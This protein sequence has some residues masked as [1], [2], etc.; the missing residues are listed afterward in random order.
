MKYSS[1]LLAAAVLLI[2]LLPA[3]KTLSPDEALARLADTGASRLSAPAR[4]A[5]AQPRLT[6]TATAADGEV[7]VYVFQSPAADGYMV[8]SADDC[9]MPL[10]GYADCGTIAAADM[11]PALEWWLGEYARQ[12]EYMRA[13][14][15]KASAPMRVQRAPIAPQIKTSWDQGEPYNA[16]CPTYGTD[17]TWTGCVATAMAQVMNYWKYPERGQGQI[18]YSCTSLE[19]R[20]SLNFALRA[21]DWDNMLDEYAGG[22]WTDAQVDAVAYL[23]KACGYA[24]KMDYGLDSSG[25]LAM[26]IPRAL[27]K[28]FNYDGNIEYVLRD[29]CSLTEWETKIYN[30]LKDVGPILYGGGSMIGGGHS[31]ICD[32]YD[33]NGYFHFNW[34]WTG[35][36][37]GYYTLD[38]LNPTS[39]GAGGG[40]GGGYNFTQDCV[41]GIQPPTG[42]PVVEQPVT[43]VQC[44]SITGS[45][46]DG[47]LYIELVGNSDPAWVNYN[48]ETLEVVFGAFVQ[49]VGSTERKVYPIFDRAIKVMPGYGAYPSTIHPYLDLDALNLPDGSYTISAAVAEQADEL[50]WRD[51]KVMWGDAPTM[52]LTRKGSDYTIDATA[53]AH[54][55]IVSARLQTPVIYGMLARVTLTATNPNDIE[56]SRG[57]A[58]VLTIN[59]ELALLG[60]SIMVSLNPGETK[61]F[62][63]ITPLYAMS[64]YFTVDKPMPCQLAF[65]DEVTY[66]LMSVAGMPTVLQPNPGVPAIVCDTP[67]VVVNATPKQEVVQDVNTIVFELDGRE[68]IEVKA[69]LLLRRGKF[70]YQVYACIAS[71]DQD[72]PEL[73][74]LETYSGYPM[75]F[76]AE[77]EKQEFNAT[78]SF[79]QGVIGQ[80]YY[81]MMGYE[82]GSQL[83]Q[84]GP[85]VSVF[86]Y[87]AS[88]VEDVCAE[89][90][91]LSYDGYNVGAP[92]H[93]I[94]IYSL[95][96]TAMTAGTDIVS[97]GAL[98]P[99]IYIAR[100]DGGKSLKITVK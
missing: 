76:S 67:P 60:E 41:L 58:P 40:E 48:P 28:Y 54:L 38:A 75:F 13:N 10:L 56:L 51:V 27:T 64:Q 14:G 77:G 73:I 70:G 47:K 87:G 89:G 49:P 97:V 71:P 59:G 65:F 52:C 16:Q 45:I 83:V 1:Q 7:A 29:C 39:L 6:Y 93:A 69:D 20:L 32:G 36:S 30:N 15:I 25:A 11:P 92:G 99:G 82:Y 86:R 94:T 31:F 26:N 63:W 84:I 91:S 8:L 53:P 21:F 68:P 88:G 44:G 24:V 96:G 81:L 62:E 61:E 46:D 78:I 79:P 42:K 22:E 95:S 80:N 55:Q 100:T 2:P 57:F 98:A 85:Y 4:I 66:G 5:S 33:G 18:T 9:A 23:M 3:A 37:N 17:R 12:I 34:G 72:N 43:L 35:M 50:E 90:S 19:K 74:A